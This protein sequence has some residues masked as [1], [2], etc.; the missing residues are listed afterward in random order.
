MQDGTNDPF[1]KMARKAVEILQSLAAQ[2]SLQIFCQAIPRGSRAGGGRRASGQ[3][4]GKQQTKIGIK[5][6]LCVNV[7]GPHDMAA[8]VG[9]FFAD[10]GMHLQ[11]PVNCDKD[12][13]Y[14]NPHL[15]FEEEE[16]VTTFSL[17]RAFTAPDTEQIG[18]APDLLELLRNDQPLNETDTPA[19]LATQL[20]R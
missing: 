12:V 2:C 8:G 20:F 13:L 5:Y 14:C 17:A 6:T 9:H 16:N 15:L 1:A 3:K 11:D 18:P 4:E 19:L 7:Y 10:C